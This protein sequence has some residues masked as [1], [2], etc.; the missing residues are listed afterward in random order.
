MH[1]FTVVAHNEAGGSDPSAR[2]RR[3]ADVDAAR[4]EI[5]GAHGRGLG[6]RPDRLVERTAQRGAISSYTVLVASENGG[7]PVAYSASDSQLSMT[8]P[9][10]KNG[11]MY[12]VQVQALN[13][14]DTPSPP[15][16]RAEGYPHGAPDQPT[17]VRA[18]SGEPLGAP[19]RTRRR[20]RSRG[21]RDARAERAGGRPRFRS[22]ASS[23]KRHQTVARP[24]CMRCQRV[25][26]QPCR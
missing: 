22:M 9:G 19:T 10:L 12:S 2:L 18:R 1:S 26:A 13:K 11:T 15:S 4:D 17:D 16:S 8:I 24:R 21:P 7:Q 14:A 23:D 20:F 6:R 3:A 25:G 5:G